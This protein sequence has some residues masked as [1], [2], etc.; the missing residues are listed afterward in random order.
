MLCEIM[1]KERNILTQRETND[2][3]MVHELDAPSGYSCKET[4]KNLYVHSAFDLVKK[5][6]I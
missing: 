5:L 3:K 1:I 4:D 6:S 2:Y